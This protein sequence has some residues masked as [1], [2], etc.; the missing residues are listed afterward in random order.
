MKDIETR[1]DLDFLL[2]N[3]YK[4]A[5]KDEQI[6]H[7]FAEMNLESHLPV[8]GDFWEKVLFGKPTYFGNP[9]AVHQ[10]LNEKSPLISKDFHHWLGIFSATIDE[11]F[12][13]EFAD[14]AKTRAG[15]I[16]NSLNRRLNEIPM[17]E[18]SVQIKR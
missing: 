1:Q 3:F 10:I 9:F 12:K 16:A 7:H 6:G 18:N 4:V 2:S 14:N 15:V 8:I 13:G 17:S 5:M 11:H